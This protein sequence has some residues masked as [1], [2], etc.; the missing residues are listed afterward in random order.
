MDSVKKRYH[1]C[2]ENTRL[3]STL[4][5]DILG[6]SDELDFVY[7][8]LLPV[9]QLYSYTRYRNNALSSNV[10]NQLTSLSDAEDLFLTGKSKS[11]KN[12]D[13][14]SINIPDLKGIDG[15][16]N[17]YTPWKLNRYE[18]TCFSMLDIVPI[19]KEVHSNIE[20]SG[21]P[22][23][24][25]LR[26]EIEKYLP[27]ELSS[28][29]A[30]IPK[31]CLEL[32][33]NEIFWF[34]IL[35]KPLPRGILWLNYAGTEE[36]QHLIALA[37]SHN[38]PSICQV[39][40]GG[41]GM[42]AS[43]DLSEFRERFF[44]SF[45]LAPHQTKIASRVPN[46]R[47]SRNLFLKNLKIPHGFCFSRNRSSIVLLLPNIAHPLSFT[48]DKSRYLSERKMRSIFEL[49]S[50]I[51]ELFRD[52]RV[53]V[54]VNPVQDMDFFANNIYHNI[55]SIIP[56]SEVLPVSMQLNEI[57]RLQ[58]SFLHVDPFCTA[59]LELTSD[60]FKNYVFFG[61]PNC[62]GL[63][64]KAKGSLLANAIFVGSNVWLVSNRSLRGLYNP[65]WLYPLSLAALFRRIF[66]D[67][68][69]NVTFIK[70]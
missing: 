55:K 30:F 31:T 18:I 17:L 70:V 39:H 47:A 29:V 60:R 11:K 6:R 49:L 48:G 5:L 8:Y 64:R 2:T 27:N 42:M 33:S 67:F 61:F 41:L 37:R 56:E 54:K 65:S 24:L 25:K 23:N 57:C 12:T 46:L 35:R 28:I 59:L 53:Y 51:N 9:V 43:E 21:I 13:S 68:Y 15:K 34:S 63:S 32:F 1:Y 19:Q 50:S 10:N 4:V 69:K 7:Y 40:G 62:P 52:Y 20:L 3:I 22:F 14:E 26:A 45:Y 38:I 44:S 58:S 36:G 16:L 66:I